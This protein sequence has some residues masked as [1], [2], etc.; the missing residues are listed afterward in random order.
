M[1]PTKLPTL[2]EIRKEFDKIQ[3][4]PRKD[5]LTFEEQVEELM[6]QIN[7][8][9]RLEDQQRAI[10]L[11]NALK[12]PKT[13]EELREEFDLISEGGVKKRN[14]T[15][16]SPEFWD[17]LNT[18]EQIAQLE[19]EIASEANI[20]TRISED[21]KKSRDNI[22]EPAKLAK[23]TPVDKALAT[24]LQKDKENEK[25]APQKF[26]EAIKK[27]FSPI[28]KLFSSIKKLFNTEK[29][30]R[31]NNIQD[32]IKNAKRI[33]QNVGEVILKSRKDQQQMKASIAKAR[34]QLIAK[35]KAQK[36]R[37]GLSTASDVGSSRRDTTKTRSSSRNGQGFGGGR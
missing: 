31:N 2:E 9:I 14:I 29:N 23:K 30:P 28:K 35:A 21:M 8:E 5:N 33:S 27:L 3:S 6:E 20:D 7:D 22:E 36:I 26:I 18:D 25:T 19:K 37:R 15:S 10:D 11:E 32:T 4:Q 12:D 16:E 1:K 34:R 24:G 13:L 17:E